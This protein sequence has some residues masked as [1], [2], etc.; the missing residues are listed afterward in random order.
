LKQLPCLPAGKA[1]SA[2]SGNTEAKN[3]Q[4]IRFANSLS[5]GSLLNKKS[6]VEK[7]GF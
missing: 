1:C 6:L 5:L 4:A 7:R 3:T 2:K